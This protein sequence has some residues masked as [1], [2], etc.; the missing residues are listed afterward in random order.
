M[1]KTHLPERISNLAYVISYVLALTTLVGGSSADSVDHSLIAR[2]K[3][4]GFQRSQVMETLS[5]LTDVH[6]PRLPGS[7]AFKAAAEWART[8]LE[9]WGLDNARHEPSGPAVPGWT[10]ERFSIDLVAPHYM[11][12]IG[13]PRAWSPT[14]PQPIA[15]VPVLVDVRSEADFDTYRGKLRGAIVMNGRPAPPDRGFQPEATR[16]TDV[17][18]RRQEEQLSPTAPGFGPFRPL[19]FREE[20]RESAERRALR[21]SIETFFDG[22]GI[23]ALLE[24]SEVA[25]GVVRVAG[26]AVRGEAPSY[27]AFVLSLEHYGR[28]ARLLDRGVPPTI[29]LFV[30][31][32]FHAADPHGSN[33]LAEIVGTD[34]ALTDEIVL[35]GA[36]LDS[37]HGGTGAI[38]NG[39]GCAVMMEAMRILASLNVKLRRTVRIALWYAE[40][41]GYLGSIGYVERHLAD[42][43]TLTPKPGLSRHS[44]YLNLDNGTGRIRGINLQGNEA[45]RPILATLLEPF[46]YLGATTLT[47]LNTGGTDHMPFDAV[48]IPA[49]QFIQDPIDYE[50]RTVH[51]SLDLYEA[52]IEDD[53]KQSAV[54]VAS[55]AYHLAMRDAMLPR[56]AAS[57]NGK[58]R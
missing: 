33:V 19:S 17:E 48:G 13:Y 30:K 5:W 44:V 45:A 49:F 42:L 15:G 31:G 18:L 24:P 41:G 1:T 54:I 29:E 28:L 11:R 3:I 46:R 25:H 43:D 52:A 53:L 47:T 10:V 14:T 8:R 58:S 23:A 32:R 57:R 2:I 21:R 34:P 40:E 36:H 26:F 22:E 16:S 56:K 27:P 7:P 38:D 6:G 37:W 51:T 35:V 50:N 39:A 4:E 12:L 55:L 9:T 20:R